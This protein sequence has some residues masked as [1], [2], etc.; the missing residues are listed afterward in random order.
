MATTCFYDFEIAFANASCKPRVKKAE[1]HDRR[2]HL[3]ETSPNYWTIQENET[4]V[5]ISDEQ[6]TQLAHLL[7]L[8]RSEP[9]SSLETTC[10]GS[11]GTWISVTLCYDDHQTS[12]RWWGSPPTGWEILEQVTQYVIKLADI[13]R[14]ALNQQHQEVVQGFF[15]QLAN[16]HTAGLLRYYHPAVQYKNPW[17]ELQ[18]NE[19]IAMWQMWWGYLPD[20]KVVV[21]ESGIHSNFVEWEA[22]YTYPPTARYIKHHL[23][24]ALT[25]AEDKIILHVD[26]F[27]I[28]RWAGDTYGYLGKVA[29]SWKLFETQVG[30]RVQ[31]QLKSYLEDQKA[32]SQTY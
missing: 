9:D 11:D 14:K 31:K 15:E 2:F 7:Q 10:F 27:N 29:G 12:Y 18:G 32:K 3:V 30:M 4:L 16:R 21:C 26:R 24:S 8:L 28:H 22:H 19:V 25:V 23:S 6:Q 20:L 5:H 13:P 17:L 1:Y